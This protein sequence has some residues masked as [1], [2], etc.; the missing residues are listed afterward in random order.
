MDVIK[1]RGGR[2]LSGTI[3]IDGAKNAALPVM[4][5]ALLARGPLTVERI[6]DLGDTKTMALLLAQL[7]VE[8]D[9][10]EIPS[11][12]I[13]L[14]AKD[15]RATR[16][17]YDLV[18]RMRASVL[19][20]GPL[21]AR[22]GRADISLPGGCAI[23]TRPIDLHLAGFT[24]LGAEI[25]LSGGYVKTR[26]PKGGLR[27]G[28]VI[29]PQVSVGATE[30]ILM[31][32][33]LARGE[34]RIENAAREPEVIDLT[35]CLIA[36]GA[37]IEGVGESTLL[38]EGSD[39]LEGGT[40]RIIA[41]RIEAGT[42]AIAAAITGGEVLLENIGSETMRTTLDVL[43]QAGAEIEENAD[44]LF[45]RRTN[46]P[47]QPLDVKTSVYPGFPTDMQAQMMSLLA[48]AKGKSRIIETIF[49]NRFMHVPELSRMGAQIE[50]S[51]SEARIQGVTTLAAAPVMATDLRASVSL[52]LAGLAAKGETIVRRVYHLD[53]GYGGLERKLRKAGGQIER[54]LAENLP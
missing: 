28:R 3:K 4:A 41:D 35:R 43:R 17:Q 11:G 29:F 16:A 25:D 15:I 32:A 26:A 27:G 39:S 23:G 44:G 13:H 33:S 5:S 18:R 1:V 49:E 48:L 38:V 2:P 22:E 14:D 6:P 20:C 45:V 12:R 8:T 51:G 10:E 24:A 7:G 36:M 21:L 9:I 30:N 53:R 52:V 54:V 42:Y 34:T 50:V 40:H 46:T 47:L 19:V 31:A 37:K